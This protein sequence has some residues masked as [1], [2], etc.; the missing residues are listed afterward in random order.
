MAHYFMHLRD[1]TDEVLD[2]EG[3]ECATLDLLRQAVMLSARDILSSDMK[4][5]VIDLRFRIDAEDSQGEVIYALPFRYAFRL[6]PE[7]A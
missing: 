5:G 2:E 1:G 3:V 6:I 7:I 4:R